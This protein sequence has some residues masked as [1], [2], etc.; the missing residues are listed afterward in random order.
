MN[1]DDL[2]KGSNTRM[3]I[4][5]HVQDCSQNENALSIYLCIVTSNHFNYDNLGAEG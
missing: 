3:F 4:H 1:F 2:G 5:N